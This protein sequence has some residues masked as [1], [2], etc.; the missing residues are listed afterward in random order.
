M[1]SDD[2]L[3]QLPV[4]P[5][6]A[7][8]QFEKIL[9]ARVQQEENYAGLE[10]YDADPYR[11]EYMS[12]VFAAVKVHGIDSLADLCVPNPG[13][14]ITEQYRQFLQDVDHVTTQ[15]R[16][17]SAQSNRQG[18]VGLDDTTRAK[19]DHFIRQIR[20]AIANPNFQTTSGMLFTIS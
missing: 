3:S 17:R 20:E 4:D 9:T 18:S 16:I 1:I 12:K 8:V 2:E 11:L 19:I 15:I 13:R 14:H 7:F 6:P 10:Q 5:E